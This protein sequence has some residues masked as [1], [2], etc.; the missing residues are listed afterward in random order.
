M[1]NFQ[2]VVGGHPG[3]ARLLRHR[4]LLQRPG[5]HARRRGRS[6][7]LREVTGRVARQMLTAGGADEQVADNGPNGHSIFTWTLLQGLEGRPTSTATASSPRPSWPRTWRPLVSSL[8]RQTPA[9]GSLPG[10]EGG[11]FVFE[12]Q[13]ETEFLSEQS[14]AARRRGDPAERRARAAA[15][16]HR[17]QAGPQ[18]AAAPAGRRRPRPPRLSGPATPP[19]PPTAAQHVRGAQRSRHGALPRE[20]L[21]RGARGVPRRDHAPRQAARWPPTTPASP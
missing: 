6:S 20:A 5:A 9:F 18:R 8:S 19:P 12:L 10:S 2:D 4:R 7:Y 21:R 1:T 13:H 11:E 16:Q 17:R 14:I 3:Q 15:R